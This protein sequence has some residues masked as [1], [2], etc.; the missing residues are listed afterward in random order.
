M[1]YFPKFA[2]KNGD[3]YIIKKCVNGRGRAEIARILCDRCNELGKIDLDSKEE[4]SNSR[5]KIS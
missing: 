3:C 5:R 2:R 1:R 4:S